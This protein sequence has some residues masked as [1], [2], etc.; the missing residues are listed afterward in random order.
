MIQLNHWKPDS[1][2]DYPVGHLKTYYLQVYAEGVWR[3]VGMFPESSQAQV[4]AQGRSESNPEALRI[5]R[6]ITSQ[7][8][9]V[10]DEST[11]QFR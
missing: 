9:E 6:V 4:V 2:G 3:T 5:V 10:I 7:L 1:F 11:H 8:V